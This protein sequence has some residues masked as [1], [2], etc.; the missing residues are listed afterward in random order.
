M[1]RLTQRLDRLSV[2]RPSRLI[3][4]TGRSQADIAADVAAAEAE[5]R[6][7]LLINT[8]VV[9]AVVGIHAQS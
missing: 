9:R 1:H 5:G 2:A 3:V 6:L 8:G 7:P 4:I